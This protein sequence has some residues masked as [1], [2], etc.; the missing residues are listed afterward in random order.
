MAS[1]LIGPFLAHASR[2]RFPT[3]FKIT[4]GLFLLDLFIPDV[5]PFIDEILLGLGALV[6]SSWQRPKDERTVIDV[7]PP[8]PPQ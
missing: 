4:L 3:L 2:L 6:L 1:P 8:A 7:E 5:I